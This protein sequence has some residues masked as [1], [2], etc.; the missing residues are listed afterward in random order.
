MTASEIKV[1]IELAFA[2][3]PH[4]G[5]NFS[6]ISATPWDEG[7]VDYFRRSTW[8]GH[9]TTNLRKHVAALSFF[10]AKAFRYWLPA[11]ILA[12]LEEPEEADVVSQHIAYSINDDSRGCLELFTAPE[13]VAISTFLT[14]CA[15]R[16][17][18]VD[19]RN[20]REKIEA[21]IKNIQNTT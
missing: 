6:D 12:E 9:Q 10:T 11:F 2:N 5:N 8:R 13:L 1:L 21:R 20:A 3:T 15:R 7:I 4:S 16:Y 18:C 14:E 17:G 19:Y